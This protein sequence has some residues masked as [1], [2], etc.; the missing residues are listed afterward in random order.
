[1]YDFVRMQMLYAL[2]RIDHHHQML[3]RRQHSF[4]FV[5]TN[6]KREDSDWNTHTNTHSC[7]T[8]SFFQINVKRSVGGKL[9]NNAQ[10]HRQRHD[11][12]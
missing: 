5:S 4:E 8:S 6:P 9:R 1:M 12:D 7:R 10:R 2:A 11:A 3:R